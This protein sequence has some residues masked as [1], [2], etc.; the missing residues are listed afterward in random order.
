MSGKVPDFGELLKTKVPDPNKM[1]AEVLERSERWSLGQKLAG[2][3]VSLAAAGLVLGVGS[4]R[5]V[6]AAV[7]A[8]VGISLLTVRR[9]VLDT[10]SVIVRDQEGR[11][12][13]LLGTTDLG[14]GIALFDDAG[15]VRATLAAGKG[16]N[17][18]LG[19]LDETGTLRVTAGCAELGASLAVFDPSGSPRITATAVGEEGVPAVQLWT[20]DGQQRVALL[21]TQTGQPQMILEDDS[22]TNF[23][24]ASAQR[25]AAANGG[26]SATVHISESDRFASFEC[27][28]N[29]AKATVGASGESGPFLALD[30]RESTAVWTVDGIDAIVTVLKNSTPVASWRTSAPDGRSQP[31]AELD[32][33]PSGA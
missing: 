11:P 26:P 30:T 9:R 28:A 32:P 19:L 31:N 24:T 4:P 14:P 10:E 16:G 15:T 12:R 33:P 7:L 23:A 27:A 25:F 8:L 1:L 29:D 3:I 5:I 6:I 13:L 2:A 22:G 17:P 20:A 18:L 21:V